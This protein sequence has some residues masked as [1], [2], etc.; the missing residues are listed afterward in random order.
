MRPAESAPRPIRPLRADRIAMFLADLQGGG[1]ERMMLS[2]AAGFRNHGAQVELIVADAVG[3]FVDEIPTAVCVHDLASG[4]VSRALPALVRFLRRERPDL[5]LTS[6]H[7]ASV[8]ALIARAL[9]RTSVPVFVREANT[10]SRRERTWRR[11]KRWI[12]AELMRRLYARADGVIAVSQGVADDMHAFYGLPPDDIAVL[13]NPVVTPEIAE[14]ARAVPDHP[15]FEGAG[16]PVVLA[17]GRL[18]PQKDFAT[19]IRAIAKLRDTTAVR[20][21]IVGEGDERAALE[22]LVGELGLEGEVSLPGFVPNPFAYMSRATVFALSSRWEGLPGALI[23]AMACG[24]PVVATDCR[25]GPAE[26]LDGGRYGELV[27]VGDADRLAEALRRT[28]DGPR[29][30]D[31][32]RTR[33]RQ[34]AQNDVAAAYL[35]FFRKRLAA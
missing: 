32:V 6:L 19:L 21:I 34:Y 24:C 12:S 23:Q 18:H 5:L 20:L 7:H 31:R 11:P 1:A 27:P 3:P 22:A 25:S 16:P 13:Y 33:S 29:D 9:S 2:L 14:R 17:A 4:G 35:D 8:I 26:I 28:I 15:W 30:A 10:P